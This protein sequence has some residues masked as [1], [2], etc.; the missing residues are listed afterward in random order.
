MNN[1]EFKNQQNEIITIF[2]RK[3]QGKTCLAKYL[4]F[5]NCNSPFIIVDPL[6]QF[7]SGKIFNSAESLWHFIV[8]NTDY[9]YSNDPILILQTDDEEKIERLYELI[10]DNL[11]NFVLLIDEVDLYFT[12]TSNSIL[13][14][15]IRYGRNKNISIIV[16]CKRP[17]LIHKD[18]TSQTDIFVFFRAS[19]Y[20][21]LDY[22]EKN[23]SKEVAK[24][25]QE[26]N[27]LQ[28]LA[29]NTSINDYTIEQ[30]DNNVFSCLNPM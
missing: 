1:I 28:F 27:H 15:I 21:D 26:L 12:N 8:N 30:I 2:G 24:K 29:Y 14:K 3:G 9:F 11:I 19:E 23:C 13:R 16:T 25:V 6:G 10:Y 7:E 20:R 22:I 17:A 18:L 4:A 5:K